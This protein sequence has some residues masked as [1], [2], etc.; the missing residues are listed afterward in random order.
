MET[1][2]LQCFRDCLFKAVVF[3]TAWLRNVRRWLQHALQCCITNGGISNCVLF[4]IFPMLLFS[5]I[6]ADFCAPSGIIQC[7]SDSTLYVAILAQ[8]L[9]VERRGC[10]AV[11]DAGVSEAQRT[12]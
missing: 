10:R 3:Q 8:D 2:R 5:R 12:P 4:R 9:R 1:K 6:N 7:F 11:A